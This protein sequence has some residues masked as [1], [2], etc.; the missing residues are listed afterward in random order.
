[1]I[2]ESPRTATLRDVEIKYGFSSK[3]ALKYAIKGDREGYCKEKSSTS[4]EG[5]SH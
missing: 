1:M 4:S 2:P 5:I 3:L